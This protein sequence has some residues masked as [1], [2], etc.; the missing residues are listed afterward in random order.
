MVSPPFLFLFR[1]YACVYLSP[2]CRSFAACKSKVSLIGFEGM[3]A[4]GDI[5]RCKIRL[6][7]NAV[8]A[9][10]KLIGSVPVQGTNSRGFFRQPAVSTRWAASWQIFRQLT[11]YRHTGLTADRAGKERQ[12][13]FAAC[14]LL[15]G[16]GGKRLKCDN[17][18]S[19][20]ITVHV[21]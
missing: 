10:S 13:P 12:I 7:K 5:L 21:G 9:L 17:L 19:E 4:N 14:H 2:N 11:A 8:Y 1:F 3:L 20:H 15:N 16:E 6:E 18:I